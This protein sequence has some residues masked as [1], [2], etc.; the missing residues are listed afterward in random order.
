MY[1]RKA[2]MQLN[3]DYALVEAL[4]LT[5][6]TETPGGLLAYDINCQYCLKLRK[7]IK[8][9]PYLSLDRSFPLDFVIG[10]FH[11]HGHK[12]ECLARFA[13]TYFPGA[14]ATSGEI[15]ES[16]WSQMN[17]SARSTRNMTL[18]RR[19]D[20][21]DALA[22][23]N[24]LRK[25]EGLR[26]PSPKQLLRA[27]TEVSEAE[28]HMKHVRNSTILGRPE[29]FVSLLSTLFE[30]LPE[31]VGFLVQHGKFGLAVFEARD[32]MRHN[33]L[34]ERGIVLEKLAEQR[35]WVIA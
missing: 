35:G 19:A 14:G 10:L 28:K 24:N 4:R 34:R 5:K 30:L 2:T 23:Y 21:L 18:G 12:D 29:G 27:T 13:P 8:K 22:W 9:G 26:S 20:T 17:P 31:L 3:V 25:L 7:R 32:E 6:A 33:G 16:L 1:S 15:L 11:V